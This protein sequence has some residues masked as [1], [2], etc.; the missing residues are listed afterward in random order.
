MPNAMQ[1]YKVPTTYIN[2]QGAFLDIYTGRPITGAD[3]THIRGPWGI[4]GAVTR[5]AKPGQTEAFV[6]DMIVFF[7][8]QLNP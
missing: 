6:D 3:D 5:G 4:R 8:A 2:D 1:F 7:R